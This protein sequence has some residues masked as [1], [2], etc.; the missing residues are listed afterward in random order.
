MIVLFETATGGAHNVI[1]QAKLYYSY[2]CLVY[3]TYYIKNKRNMLLLS[4]LKVL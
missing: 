3:K 4:V 2:K 1:V